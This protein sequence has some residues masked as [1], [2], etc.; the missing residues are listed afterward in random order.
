VQALLDL[1]ETAAASPTPPR[2][3]GVAATSLDAEQF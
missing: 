2:G 1:P 3:A